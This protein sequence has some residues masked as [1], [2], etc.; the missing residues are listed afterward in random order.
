MEFD[1][2][3]IEN[4]RK[5]VLNHIIN[6]DYFKDIL[7]IVKNK[8][9]KD[10]YEG[11]ELKKILDENKQRRV[12]CILRN[13]L[14]EYSHAVSKCL[15]NQSRYKDIVYWVYSA[16]NTIEKY[17]SG[18]YVNGIIYG[19]TI[20]ELLISY[21]ESTYDTIYEYGGERWGFQDQTLRCAIKIYLKNP[22]L[23]EEIKQT[24]IFKQYYNKYFNPDENDS[25]DYVDDNDDKKDTELYA[26]KYCYDNKSIDIESVEELE[27]SDIEHNDSESS[28]SSDED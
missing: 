11:K 13:E 4:K 21:L 5:I 7:N 14:N 10:I 17:C 23:S 27:L 15:S 1:N 8:Y 2:L 6:D 22:Y 24:S 20:L 12:A 16:K 18:K 28:E 19:T 9:A 26:S 25:D 3:S